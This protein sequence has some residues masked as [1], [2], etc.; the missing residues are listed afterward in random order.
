MLSSREYDLL[1]GFLEAV[2]RAPSSAAFQALAVEHV[3][4]AL[5][6]DRA[7]FFLGGEPGETNRVLGGC[8]STGIAA[9]QTEQYVE[10]WQAS[11]VFKSADAVAQ[12]RRTG[13]CDLAAL[14]ARG[15]RARRP[16]QY[17]YVAEF[18]L[19]AGHGAQLT[20]WLPTGGRVQGYVT[21]LGPP[22]RTWSPSEREFLSTL[23][24]HLGHLLAW[25]LRSDPRLLG[26][27]EAA[28]ALSAR[29]QDVVRLLAEGH[30]NRAIARTLGI[31]EDTVKKHVSHALTKV[32][33]T[34]R[35]QLALRVRDAGQ[36]P[37]PPAPPQP[38]VFPT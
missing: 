13:V 5:H 17:R 29:E 20:A 21:V 30:G 31:S 35:T 38:E 18:L 19:R 34:S 32:G 15:L 27:A 6:S 12:H 9:A 22:G 11:D 37:A 1:L 2:E 3:A 10:R 28:P 25:H 14:D 26:P 16:D 7:T 4:A 24:P 23:R 36:V 33:V 8:A